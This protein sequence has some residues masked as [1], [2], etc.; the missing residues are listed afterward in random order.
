M[1]RQGQ[2]L[3]SVPFDPNVREGGDAGKPIVSIKPDSA[4][5]Q[6]LNQITQKVVARISVINLEE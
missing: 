2:F 4:A 6:A 3:G 1:R 5:A